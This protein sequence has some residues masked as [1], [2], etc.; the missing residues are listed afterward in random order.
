MNK[1]TEKARAGEMEIE[2]GQMQ[3]KPTPTETR[4]PCGRVS[5]IEDRDWVTSKV[6]RVHG[7]DGRFPE[8]RWPERQR[9][10]GEVLKFLAESMIQAYIQG[11]SGEDL[12]YELSE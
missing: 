10:L 12:D 8:V 6:V 9:T 11:L 2:S 7:H 3:K 1:P 4:S 5:E